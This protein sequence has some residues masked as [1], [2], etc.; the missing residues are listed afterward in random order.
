MDGCRTGRLLLT[1]GTESHLP[2]QHVAVSSH[3]SQLSFDAAV[4][5]IVD[6]QSDCLDVTADYKCQQ[7]FALSSSLTTG[8]VV[9]GG[10]Y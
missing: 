8:T 1:E 6:V 5:P 2:T 4:F 10:G 9:L 3:S 7:G